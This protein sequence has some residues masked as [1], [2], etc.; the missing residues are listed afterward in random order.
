MTVVNKK[1]HI[2]MAFIKLYTFTTTQN[3]PFLEA[4]VNLTT[5]LC[6]KTL[7]FFW[8][9]SLVLWLLMYLVTPQ[10]DLSLTMS[11]TWLATKQP[12]IR[13]F[14][15]FNSCFSFRDVNSLILHCFSPP[16]ECL[17]Y[18]EYMCTVWHYFSPF[19]HSLRRV[20]TSSVHSEIAKKL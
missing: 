18:T 10:I 4:E 8:L 7:F 20:W 5:H 19:S 11:L 3:C 12:Y 17:I 14:S 16:V 13:V 1:L 2:T 9:L 15:F 6:I